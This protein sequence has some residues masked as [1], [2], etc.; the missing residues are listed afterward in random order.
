MAYRSVSLGLAFLGVSAL[1]VEAQNAAD[2]SSSLK[3]TRVVASPATVR[4]EAGVRDSVKFVAYDAQG[5]IVDAPMRPAG[6]GQRSL[7]LQAFNCAA[8]AGC[9]LVF[10]AKAEGVFQVTATTVLPAGATQ[11]PATVNA[12]VN[13]TWPA[14]AQVEVT[15]PKLKLY[16]GTTLTHSAAAV[17][18]DQSKRP[19]PV[20]R[21]ASSNPAVATV[22]RFGNVTALRPGAVTITAQLEGA[23]GE[24]RHVVP[25]FTATRFEITTPSDQIKTGDVIK[26]GL[27]ATAASGQQVTDLPVTWSYTFMP[28]DSIRA[29]GA[30]GE[31]SADGR[32]VA[33]VPGVYTVLAS[34]GPLQARKAVDVRPREAIRPINLVGRGSITDVHTADLWVF[35]GKNKRDYA[36]VGTWGGDGWAYMFDVTDPASIVK[37]DS[38]KIDARTINDV[39]VSPDARWGVLARE[40]ASNRRNGVVILDLADPAHPRITANFDEDLT[41]GVHNMFATNDHLFALSAGDKYVI[42]DVKDLSKPRKISEYN[43]PNSSI[44][45]VTVVDGIAYSS[46]WGSGVV[47][48]D[49][50]NGKWGGT[51]EKPVFINNYAYPVGATHEVYIQKQKSGKVYAYLG[52][53]IMSRRGAAWAGT[54]AS[55]TAKGGVPQ[56]MSGYVHIVDVTDPMAPQ[57][58]AR[59]EIKEFGSHDV[60][61]EGDI[62]YQAYYDGGLRVIDVG[63]DLMGD[64][65]NQGREIAVF[66]PYDPQGYT[67]NA[68]M[69]MNAQPYKGHI[70]VT[71]FNS[72]LWSVKLEPKKPKPAT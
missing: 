65:A 50:G 11:S 12:A 31:V 17:H 22:D 58:V 56:T 51:L 37:T 72:G 34:A 60:V 39:T 14:I 49:V 28:D 5:N 3:V 24:V 44:H 20:F 23:R 46:E 54:N 48:V 25:A 53:E 67:A 55:L 13:V 35:E 32:F 43:H 29:P 66:K 6:P 18:R 15:T 61:V 59:Y 64:L 45:D 36:L 57:D 4:A 63:G 33:E 9:T 38:I 40:G 68:P 19:N 2:P 47:M 16:P 8:G 30:A 21:W 26:L 71:D 70:F 1:S 52:D 10:T 7:Q 41:G 42:I 62:L 27:K 69:V